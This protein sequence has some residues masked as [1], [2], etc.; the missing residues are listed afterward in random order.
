MLV[1]TIATASLG[2]FRVTCRSSGKSRCVCSCCLGHF[3]ACLVAWPLC[4]GPACLAVERPHHTLAQSS[5]TVLSVSPRPDLE[6]LLPGALPH[7]PHGH[8]LHLHGLH[9]QRLLLQGFQHLRLFLER[10][11]H[12]QKWHMEVSS[13]TGMGCS[14]AI[15]G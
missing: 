11:T 8:L 2:L 10:P 15:Y 6:H 4:I 12:V 13:Q 5:L 3:G 14:L 9:L 1:S 7:P